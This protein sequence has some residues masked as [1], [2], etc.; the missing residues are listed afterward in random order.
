MRLDSKATQQGQSEMGRKVVRTGMERAARWDMGQ[1]M[2]FDR[3]GDQSPDGNVLEVNEG[4]AVISMEKVD[5]AG[6]H[7]GL[8]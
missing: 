3:E 4:K 8:Q 7:P 1:Q 6:T 2:R 5:L